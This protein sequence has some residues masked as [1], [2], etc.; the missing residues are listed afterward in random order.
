MLWFSMDTD[1]VRLQLLMGL[2]FL[3]ASTWLALK[4][5]ASTRLTRWVLLLACWLFLLVALAGLPWPAN[6]ERL[7]SVAP[8]RRE[9]T[10]L[11]YWWTVRVASMAWL[12]AIGLLAAMHY[13]DR[14][15]SPQ[16]PAL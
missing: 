10:L 16:T 1:Q 11:T 14:R 2:P 13:W 6:V 4:R 15:N 9:S 8:E 12:V 3:L 7:S 5:R